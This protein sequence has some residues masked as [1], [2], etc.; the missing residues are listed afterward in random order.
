[1]YVAGVWC[2]GEWCI[3]VKQ[4]R[5]PAAGGKSAV[6]GGRGGAERAEEGAARVCVCVCAHKR[7]RAGGAC[8]GTGV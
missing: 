1:M 3:G 2:V 7:A 8:Y 4:A 6:S 5:R